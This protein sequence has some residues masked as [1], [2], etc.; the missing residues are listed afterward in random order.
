MRIVLSAQA[1]GAPADYPSISLRP[2]RPAAAG[3]PSSTP[4]TP[5]AGATGAPKTPLTSVLALK[6]IPAH[7]AITAQQAS[8][9]RSHPLA[10]ESLPVTIGRS[11]DQT[12]VIDRRYQ[13]VS[14]QHV[15]IDAVD[16]NGAHGVVHGDNGVVIDGVA[17]GPGARF[18]WQPGQTLV[19]G[20]SL[21]GEPTCSL[22]LARRSEH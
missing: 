22:L 8:G 2:V 15:A 11:R 9:E 17:F 19:L 21:P 1:E 6:P 5:I 14:G 20:G 3:A 18:D 13:G 7:F 16:E 12:V 10:S 4:A